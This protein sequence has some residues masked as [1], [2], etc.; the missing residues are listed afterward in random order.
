MQYKSLKS[1]FII[2][3]YCIL[4]YSCKGTHNQPL[5]ASLIDRDTIYTCD[6]SEISTKERSL[7]LS[8]LIDSFQIVYFEN[9]D[10]A[11]FKFWK[12]YITEHY[13]GILQ[14]GMLPFKLFDHK[15]GFKCNVGS[16]GQG[17]G[18]YTMLYSS[19]IHE[20]DS[21][22]WLIP[23]NGNCLLKYDLN[24]NCKVSIKTRKMHKPVIRYEKDGTLTATNL[25]FKDIPGFLYLRLFREDS[26]RYMDEEKEYAFNAYD[27]EGNFSGFNHEIWFYN[28][29]EHFTY[30]TTLSNQL[31]KY[32]IA[33]EQTR[34][35]LSI[36][37][38]PNDNAYMILDELPSSFLIKIYS[39]DAKERKMII[40]NKFTQEAY[41]AKIQ[42]DFMGNLPVTDFAPRDG[43]YYEMFEPIE[44]I[45]LIETHL[46][47]KALQM[48][49]KKKLEMLLSS[50]DEE[51]N[52][53]LFMGK[54]KQK[55]ICFKKK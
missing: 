45:D 16:V 25:Y 55:N 40:A 37:S 15:G 33:A 10:K 22:I 7:K 54:L 28:N 29:T 20:K 17:P 47:D 36:I 34:S 9:S 18:E 13:I 11:L 44:L 50:I 27:K 49:D 5:A 48:E 53:I 46:S 6:L 32:D 39:F 21:S 43:W 51:A 26:L 38:R 3:I 42:N 4:L 30:M 19:T 23:F 41:Y 1:L 8:E 12:A 14:D 2:Y 52:N 35:R 31:Y 24:G